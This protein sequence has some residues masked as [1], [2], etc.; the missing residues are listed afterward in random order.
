[1]MR[2]TARFRRKA[3][4]QLSRKISGFP[5]TCGGQEPWEVICGVGPGDSVPPPPRV[6]YDPRPRDIPTGAEGGIPRHQRERSPIGET[7]GGGGLGP[8]ACRG[9]RGVPWA[10][11]PRCPSH[12]D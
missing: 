4:E 10:W 2:K 3:R 11:G 5:V 6:F 9:T 1:M 12:H 8:S 7:F